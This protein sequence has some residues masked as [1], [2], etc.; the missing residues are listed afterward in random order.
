[1]PILG[2]ILTKRPIFTPDLSTSLHM[3]GFATYRD[4]RQ[5][6]L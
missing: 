5:V 6:L 4:T 3:D 2:Q 1:M